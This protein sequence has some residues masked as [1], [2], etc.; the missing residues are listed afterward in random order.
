M[1]PHTATASLFAWASTI[2]QSREAEPT[3]GGG[4]AR[5]QKGQTVA[6]IATVCPASHVRGLSTFQSA[7]RLGM[8]GLFVVRRQVVVTNTSLSTK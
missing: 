3:G 4:Q 2:E 5:E 6:F 8:C 1:Q 7:K